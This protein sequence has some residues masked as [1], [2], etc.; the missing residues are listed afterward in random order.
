[1]RA[2]NTRGRILSNLKTWW[3]TRVLNIPEVQ[4]DLVWNDGQKKLLIDSILRKYDVPKLYFRVVLTDDGRTRYDVYDGQ[5]RLNAI[6]GFMAGEFALGDF[7]PIDFNGVEHDLKGKYFSELPVPV[8]DE[9][10]NS[11]LDCVEVQ[12]YS[13]DEM[14]DLFLRLQKGEPL[15]A[16]EKR[17]AIPGTMKNV[18]A[19]LSVHDIF[20]KE[21]FVQFKDKR[22]AY[23]DAIAK[24]LHQ[25]IHDDCVSI[26]AGA[27]EKTYRNNSSIEESDSAPKELKAC[28]SWVCNHF[29][30]PP[31]LKKF[32]FITTLFLIKKLRSEY[33]LSGFEQE[34]A[35]AIINFELERIK[36]Q[37]KQLEDRNP[38]FVAYGDY[39][40]SD[41]PPNMRARLNLL[42]EF[43][44]REVEALPL[45]DSQRSFTEDQRK[46]LWWRDGKRCQ[47]C[48][49]EVGF[50][51]FH[52]D[53]ITAHSLGGS[54]SIAN[55]RVLCVSCNTSRGVGDRL[56]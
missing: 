36:D 23:Q 44:L 41:S 9:F 33:A 31:L 12:G 21:D 37:E 56:I 28:M 50:G 34:V 7:G 25:F 14:D 6:M 22:Y 27:I 20:S 13:D 11:T 8:I 47:E 48:E 15:N 5:Q 53:H 51:E 35:G 4:R 54:T 30:D 40:R 26:S 10:Q 18:V 55:G 29:G 43:V 24:V 2:M 32:S 42:M 19:S 39:A 38:E 52:A 45:K 17:R 16:A 3:D 46:V 1:M 49:V